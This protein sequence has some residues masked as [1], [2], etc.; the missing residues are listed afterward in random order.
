MIESKTGRKNVK[1][2]VMKRGELNHL[3]PKEKM[4]EYRKR[5]GRITKH[6]DICDIIVSRNNFTNHTRSDNHKN[7]E[8]ILFLTTKL[9]E[10]N[11]II[12]SLSRNAQDTH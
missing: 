12:A 5:L 9:E 6:C 1:R 8:H 11:N 7:K 3:P 4:A 2:N 10:A